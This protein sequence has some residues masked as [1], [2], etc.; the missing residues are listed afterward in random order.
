MNYPQPT[1]AVSQLEQWRESQENGKIEKN[2]E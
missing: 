2:G 1:W